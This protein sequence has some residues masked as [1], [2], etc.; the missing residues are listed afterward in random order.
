MFSENIVYLVI[1][2]IYRLLNERIEDRFF[3]GKAILL[4]GPRQVGKT[5][6]IKSLIKNK[7]HLF[8]NGDDPYVRNLLENADSFSLKEIIGTH[9]LIFIDEAQR[10]PN[11]GLTVKLLTDQFE[12]VQVLVSGSSALELNDKTQEPLTGRKW[13]FQ[14]YPISW[15]EF[16]RHVGFI[17]AE[18]QLEHRLVYGMYPEVVVNPFDAQEILLQLANSYL[19]KDVL[20]LTGIRKPDLLDRLLKAIALQLGNEVSYTELADLLGVDKSTIMKYI[21]LLEKT[22]VIFTLSSFSRNQRNEIKNNRKIYFYDTGIRNVLISNLNPISL[23]NDTGALWE[24]FLI[25]E[26][27]KKQAYHAQTANK[28]FW[29]TVQK[30]EI[31]YV[32]ETG[33]NILAFE[34]KWK[35]A[36]KA[37]LP[38]SFLETYSAQGKI[39]DRSNFR[40][41]VR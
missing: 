4:L 29:R 28:F 8:L 9:T 35:N 32:E 21:D 40:E 22:F 1:S 7:P 30:Q 23:R 14:M 37:K 19:Y 13:E 39:I 26:R 31:D 11:I 18:Q 24:N 12:Q 5:T 34:F 6:L 25:A 38:K 3:N 15:E 20:A 17:E 10:I 16:E 36:A 41:F 27:I 33:G 2:M